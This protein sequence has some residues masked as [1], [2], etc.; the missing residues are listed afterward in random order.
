[1]TVESSAY[2]RLQNALKEENIQVVTLTGE[3]NQELEDVIIAKYPI[4]NKIKKILLTPLFRKWMKMNYNLIERM[5]FSLSIVCEDPDYDQ[6]ILNADIIHLHWICNFLSPRAI[7]RLAYLGKPIVWTCHDSWPFTG[8]CHVR[9]NCQN[10]RTGCGRC[11]VLRSKY[12]HDMTTFIY[13]I[14]KKCISDLPITLIAP[15]NWMK[16]NIENSGLFHNKKC[17]VIPNTLDLDVF[18]E[19]DMVYVSNM[20]DYHKDNKKIHL[21][22]GAVAVNIP[23]KG[24]SYLISALKQLYKD[25]ED[26]ANKIV[27]HLVGANRYEEEILSWYECQYW[28]Y[29]SD[30]KMMACIYNMADMLV[31]PTIEDN[32]PGMI[33]ESLAC[34]TPV[35]TFDTGGVGDMVVH[36]VNGYI[37]RHGDSKDLLDGILWTIENNNNNR[38]GRKGR[39]KIERDFNPQLIAQ[40]HI[41][42]YYSLLEQDKICSNKKEGERVESL[43]NRI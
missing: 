10:F 35:V 15:S 37:A 1:M 39:K 23:Y 11:P 26:I 25:Y 32:L 20:L 7:K 12:K 29:V 36:K 40:K 4:R 17:L 5:P 30:Q 34:A 28:D 33:M 38:L 22:F 6:E 19:K 9:Y 18:S 24:I 42:L 8:G 14:K 43:D 16:N 27:L 2:Y 3:C 21:L 41:D 13:N 31:F